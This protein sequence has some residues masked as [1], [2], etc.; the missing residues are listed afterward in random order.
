MALR[1][2]FLLVLDEREQV[3]L[4]QVVPEVDLLGGEQLHCALV[5]E[6]IVFDP[7]RVPQQVPL[8][9]HNPVWESYNGRETVRN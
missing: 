2:L 8:L 7:Q 3:G 6:Q 9:L 5:G 4:D 1:H